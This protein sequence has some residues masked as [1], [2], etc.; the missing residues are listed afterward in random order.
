MLEQECTSDARDIDPEES[1]FSLNRGVHVHLEPMTGDMTE[2]MISIL[3]KIDTAFV[4][5]LG[6][7]QR[8]LACTKCQEKGDCG[9]FR[10]KEGIR[11]ASDTAM[12]SKKKHHPDQELVRLMKK[13]QKPF[14]MKNLLDVE[15]S[16]LKL[17]A[18]AESDIK[19]AMLSGR[20]ESGEQIWIYHDH[21]T[22]PCNL[23][24]RFNT[25]AHVVIYIGATKGIHEVVH[26][27]KASC[28]R[29]PMKAKIRRQNVMEVIKPGD[30]VFLGHKIPN[31]ELSANLRKEI[32]IRAK[33]C[34]E[35]P[36]I[37][38]D[39]HYRYY[40]PQN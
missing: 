6:D 14:E 11:L 40:N 21:R 38:F 31:C 4:P 39:Y 9:C 10:V 34:T 20:L 2:D 33:K 23:V 35:K 24:A 5:Y 28:T 12:C 27:S 15:R 7:V 30:Q 8:S 16:S 37:V 25:Y 32:V 3:K 19:K 29:G 1:P 22:N 13:N 18:F 17:Q 26:I 36:S